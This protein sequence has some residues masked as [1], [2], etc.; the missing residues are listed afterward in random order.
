MEANYLSILIIQ[1]NNTKCTFLII[2]NK[3]SQY[4]DDTLLTLDG[5]PNSLFAAF[6]SFDFF[7]KNFSGLKV[8]CLKTKIIWLGKKKSKQV[9]HH[10]KLET[11]LGFNNFCL[12]GIHFFSEIRKHYIS[13]T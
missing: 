7:P 12:L 11:R 10:T 5:S 3:I 4:P 8:N 2:K 9:F 13:L 1:N 6:D